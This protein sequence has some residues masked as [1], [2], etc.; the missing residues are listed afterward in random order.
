MRIN[1]KFKNP[2]P[3]RKQKGVILLFSLV[4]MVIL[5]AG[6][7]AVVKSMNS[8]LSVA[9]NLAFRRDLVNQ[10][11]LVLAEIMERMKP[12]GSLAAIGIN[13]NTNLN[14]SSIL[15]PGNAEGI[16]IPLIDD[17][18]FSSVGNAS[19]DITETTTGLHSAIKEGLRGT[20]IRYLIERMCRE[21][22]PATS[23]H[24]IESSITPTG[25]SGGTETSRPPALK[26]AVYR[27][28]IRVTGPR[29]TQVF[30]QASINKP[31]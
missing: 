17:S 3:A 20:K 26:A 2:T 28:N 25:G 15:L 14:Y 19:N 10:A 8:S 12:G 23:S 13:S 31:D 24:C 29:D 4:V 9:G 11:E 1:S 7:I 5:F 27:V 21:P 6:S 30:I 22:E 18:Q 16:P